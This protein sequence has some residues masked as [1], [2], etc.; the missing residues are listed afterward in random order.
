MPNPDHPAFLKA[1]VIRYR[2]IKAVGGHSNHNGQ[3]TTKTKDKTPSRKHENWKTRKRA[4]LF[5]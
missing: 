3:V 2:L 5:L 4:W 1:R